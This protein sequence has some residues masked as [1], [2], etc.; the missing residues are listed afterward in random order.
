MLP[1]LTSETVITAHRLNVT[2]GA[3]RAAD[4]EALEPLPARAFFAEAPQA[5]RRFELDLAKVSDLR[6]VDEALTRFDALTTESGPKAGAEVRRLELGLG[7]LIRLSPSAEEEAWSLLQSTPAKGEILRMVLT[8]SPRA[9]SQQRVVHLLRGNG[10][11]LEEQ[12]RLLMALAENP[13]PSRQLLNALL[14]LQETTTLKDTVLMA[15]GGV[16]H[17]ATASD[18]ALA[19]VALSEIEAALAT[20]SNSPERLAVTLRAL[21]N[22]GHPRVWDLTQPYLAH[23]SDVVRAAAVRALRRVEDVRVDSELE[24]IRASD[25][26]DSV[27]KV[28]L[29]IAEQRQQ[30]SLGRVR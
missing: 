15:I 27:Q 29:A 3:L 5:G 4:A 8:Q 24:S 28:V 16:C 12:S 14:Q 20:H 30:R 6:S 2:I 22:A 17:E 1:Q 19:L 11:P 10:L 18:P 23:K 21:G 25:K 13:L 7:A 26:S 9:E